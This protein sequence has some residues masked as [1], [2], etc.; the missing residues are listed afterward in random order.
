MQADAHAVPKNGRQTVLLKQQFDDVHLWSD[1]DPY[2]YTAVITLKDDFRQATQGDYC[3]GNGNQ[4]G[5]TGGKLWEV[6]G[7]FPKQQNAQRQ[8]DRAADP[9]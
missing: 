6:P 9:P 3:G 8:Q 4:I 2:L 1:E 5:Q 7:E